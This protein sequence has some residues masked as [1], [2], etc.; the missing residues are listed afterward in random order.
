MTEATLKS[1]SGKEPILPPSFTPAPSPVQGTPAPPAPSATPAT[2]PP[3]PR[4]LHATVDKSSNPTYSRRGK[5]RFLQKPKILYIGDSVAQ[6]AD[7]AYLERE[8]QSRIRT[9]KAYS[10]ISDRKARWPK[11]N[12]MD[13]TPVALVE[14]QKE[15]AF[16][17]LILAAPTVDISNIDTSKLTLNDNKSLNKK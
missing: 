3:G 16:S 4:P 12:F 15:D 1:N 17:H 11:K 14:T 7:I 10:S 2:K 9:K 8:T 6:N 13:V 5:S